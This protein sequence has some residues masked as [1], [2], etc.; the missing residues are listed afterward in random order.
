MGLESTILRLIVATMGT[1]L[2]VVLAALLIAGRRPTIARASA[3]GAALSA[4]VWH[5]ASCVKLYHEV[6][7]ASPDPELFRTLDAAATVGSLAAPA[8]L[9]H[10][11]LV[12]AGLRAAW[13]IPAYGALLLSLWSNYRGAQVVVSA[14]VGACLTVSVCLSLRTAKRKTHA[15]HRAFYATLAASLGIVTVAAFAGSVSVPLAFSSLLPGVCL[16]YFIGR[17]NVLGLLLGR[18]LLFVFTLAAV[19][20]VYLL[21]VRLIADYTELHFEAFAALVELTLVLA[22][23]VLWLPLFEWITRLLSMRSRQ[24]LEYSKKII[25]KADSILDRRDRVQYLADEVARL[26]QLEKVLIV[27]S[28]EPRLW[29]CHGGGSGHEIEADLAA[30]E[31]HIRKEKL[32]MLHARRAKTGQVRQLLQQ[33]EYNYVFA[34][35]YKESV[36]GLM[37]IDTSPRLY[38]DEQEPVL[39]N[40]SHEISHSLESCRLVDE[41]I[42]LEKALLRQEH[43]ASLGKV[44]A[45]IAHEV[46]NPLSSIKTLAQLMRDDPLIVEKYSRDV[47][48]IVSETD[49]LASCVG[50]LLTF[51]RPATEPG[52]EVPIHDV[53]ETTAAMLEREYSS[54]QIRV[55]R[56]IDDRLRSLRADRQILQQIVLNLSLNAA[57]ACDIAGTVILA[58]EVL[59]QGDIRIAVTDDGPGIPANIREQIF[60]PFF[61]TKKKGTGLGM[62]I[63]KKN[64]VQLGG[65]I[66]VDSPLQDGKGTRVS[67]SFPPPGGDKEGA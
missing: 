20:T 58:G 65:N 4:A 21:V 49:R 33:H 39:L 2:Y 15:S 9:L 48:F 40:L 34:L 43:L 5:C 52:P 60:Q 59:P 25:E 28:Q 47:G 30:L 51:S 42:G 37:L 64:A 66:A 44:A 50:Q 29:C 18:R 63:V 1:A 46:K 26:F 24:Y 38:L 67:V 17:Y 41:K 6:S 45:T 54:K 11:V 16:L 36:I 56:K 8:F 35:R 14:Y 3:L 19:S 31:E 12:W 55:R 13:G 7:F 32:E 22:V 10:L 53:L 61:T 62:A 27:S 57:Q 23:A